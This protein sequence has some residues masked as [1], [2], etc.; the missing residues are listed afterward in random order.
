MTAHFNF[1]RRI[2]IT[3]SFGVEFAN[4]DSKGTVTLRLW[5]SAFTCTFDIPKRYWKVE[6]EKTRFYR[7]L[8]EKIT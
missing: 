7:E 3:P 4:Y 5:W 8:R 2:G 6:D 1:H